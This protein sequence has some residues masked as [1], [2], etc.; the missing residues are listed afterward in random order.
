MSLIFPEE[1][2][3]SKEDTPA[4]FIP[5]SSVPEVK[6]GNTTNPGP[7]D[8]SAQVGPVRW[9][10][11]GPIVPNDYKKPLFNDVGLIVRAKS[12]EGND[13]LLWIFIYRQ[14]G[15]EIIIANDVTQT[16]FVVG[17]FTDKEKV[18]MHDTPF[19]SKGQNLEDYY[20]PG[21]IEFE[22]TDKKTSWKLGGREMGYLGDGK[23]YAKGTH[24]GVETDLIFTQRGDYFYHVS[25]WD[26]GFDKKLPGGIAGGN[27][28]VRV[29]GTIKANGKTYTITNGHGMQ[30]RIVMAGFIPERINYMGKGGSPWMHGW[31]EQLSFFTISRDTGHNAQFSV[32]VDGETLAV[33]GAGW[34]I[35][36]ENEQWLDP[37]T[38]QA[39]PRR[40]T[41]IATTTKGRFQA[42]VV[43]FARYYYTWIRRHGVLVVHQF[44]CDTVMTFTRNDGSVVSEKG[45]GMVEYMRTLYNQSQTLDEESL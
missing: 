5:S 1:D 7:P 18:H 31:G 13:V 33:M 17:E 37:K 29:N 44:M 2:A 21:A 24:A 41:V 26:T 11:Q 19:I 10:E 43:G 25:A 39:N 3:G 35:T 12:D 23:W 34:A 36:K 32:N 16:G 30:E 40:W 20:H 14:Q 45:V 15:P 22:E 4:L 38:K 8:F 42:S 9:D 6:Y 27:G 28:H